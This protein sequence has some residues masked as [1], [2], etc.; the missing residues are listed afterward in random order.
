MATKL[1][2]MAMNTDLLKIYPAIYSEKDKMAIMDLFDFALLCSYFEGQPLFSLEAAAR[3]V[4][5][6]STYASNVSYPSDYAHLLLA[7][8]HQ[9]LLSL[10]TGRLPT[11][12]YAEISEAVLS[13][14]LKV[15]LECQINS[16][17]TR[18]S[19]V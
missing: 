5:T 7:S 16:L 9:D 2:E 15:S 13:H 18:I 8:N 14:S 17:L 10:I 6:I 1:K 3:G 11:E 4:P 19:N 12:N